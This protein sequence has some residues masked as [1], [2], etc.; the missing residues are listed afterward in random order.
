M[1]GVCFRHAAPTGVPRTNDER[2][3]HGKLHVAGAAGL[4]ARGG[5]VLAAR[6]GQGGR[7][8]CGGGAIQTRWHVA[9]WGEHA[10]ASTW[11]CVPSFCKQ[12]ALVATC[13]DHPPELSAG[14]DGLCHRHVVVW[15]ERNLQ[16][17]KTEVRVSA[18]RIRAQQQGGWV[19]RSLKAGSTCVRAADKA[20]AACSAAAAAELPLL[21]SPAAALTLSRSPTSGSLLTCG[22]QAGEG[23]D[24]L[25]RMA[26]EGRAP[27]PRARLARGSASAALG[28]LC[29]ATAQRAVRICPP[30]DPHPCP[31]PLPPP[32][33]RPPCP[34]PPTPA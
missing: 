7:E 6:A 28:K 13:R 17:A 18:R 25:T 3:V 31:P 16:K 8:P 27:P 22:R 15:H 34:P 12:A 5:D 14:D 11:H 9:A 32:H 21:H 1:H 29:C 20:A 10:E 26:I 2:A 24:A 33:P 4:G 23:H 19:A 30:W